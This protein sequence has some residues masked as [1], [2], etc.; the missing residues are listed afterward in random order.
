MASAFEPKPTT[1]ESQSDCH[2]PEARRPPEREG[3]VAVR[4]LEGQDRHQ[5]HRRVK[6]EQEDDEVG[7]EADLRPVPP[8]PH[9]AADDG[10]LRPRPRLRRDGRKSLDQSSSRRFENRVIT[11]TP[12]IRAAT[13]STAEAA[14]CGYWIAP[15]FELTIVP[16]DVML[17]PPITCTVP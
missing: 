7:A 16:T 14:P 8:V 5:D 1:D 17:P 9:L 12:S 15:I 10:V 6:E 2:Q 13:R 11:Q 3:E 4:A